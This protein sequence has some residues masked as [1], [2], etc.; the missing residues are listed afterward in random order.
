MDPNVALLM[1]QT[2][3]STAF[4]TNVKSLIQASEDTIVGIDSQM[5]DL[6]RLRDRER[7]V[8]A[9][10]RSA[11]VPVKKLSAELLVEIFLI[12]AMPVPPLAMGYNLLQFSAASMQAVL[13]VSQVSAYWR[14]IALTTPRLWTYFFSLYV[15]TK[16]TEGYLTVLKLWL[17]RS[18][19]LP[20]PVWVHS[21]LEPGDLAPLMRVLIG[22]ANRWGELTLTGNARASLPAVIPHQLEKLTSVDFQE[23]RLSSSRDAANQRNTL[24]MGAPRLR[25]ARIH[26]YGSILTSLPWAQLT[27][28]TLRD[29]SSG[30]ECLRLD[31]EVLKDC[32]NLTY[33]LLEMVG[34]A[35]IHSQVVLPQLATFK[36]MSLD[37]SQMHNI[38]GCIICPRLNSLSV[39][40]WTQAERLPSTFPQFQQGSPC[41]TEINFLLM[42]L[43]SAEL[44]VMLRN[45]PLLERLHLLRCYRCIDDKL[46]NALRYRD[47][48]PSPLAPA[49]TL[50]WFDEVG[51]TFSQPIL[52][53]A[54]RSR[55]WTNEDLASIP[56]DRHPRVKRWKIFLLTTT[57]GRP[58]DQTFKAKF[59]DCRAKGLDLRLQ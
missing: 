17:D 6:A 3:A 25:K 26:S 11:I 59:E 51:D 1:R 18:S 35:E 15:K 56:S 27:D 19:P 46:L 9:T 37:S 47:S 21:S 55:W 4:E 22:G 44:I 12:L 58:F 13:A 42:Q 43:T 50:V 2:S 20:I 49:L 57:P 8:I 38:L 32:G 14:N 39:Y 41:I 33:F 23:Y 28:L 54:I 5:R 53:T 45:S 24:L 31:S 48:D 36:V 16:P 30:R 52:E 29:S 34:E 10:L 7:G 40:V